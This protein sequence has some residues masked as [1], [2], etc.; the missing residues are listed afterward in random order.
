MEQVDNNFYNYI[1]LD[2]NKKGL[3]KINGTDINLDYE[4]FYVG[5]GKNKRFLPCTHKANKYLNNKIKKLKDKLIICKIYKGL[6]E[7]EA[8]KNEIF[9]IKSIGK[10]IDKKG[11]LV[12]FSDGGNGISGY[13]HTN[14]SIIKISNASK[15]RVV[16]DETKLKLSL[17]NK[18]KNHPLYGKKLKQS[19]IE[20]LKEVNK[21]C[22]SIEHLRKIS[23]SKMK[24]VLKIDLITNDILDEFKSVKDAMIITGLKSIS[25][26]CRGERNKCGNFKWKYV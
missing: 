7:E 15:K 18:G 16:S 17:I 20:K 2:G 5:K 25:A 8:I 14:E 9:L 13:K 23:E 24:K 26:V 12:N 21:G 19:H 3:Y 11:T 10:I 6:T 22:K 4:P 1:Y